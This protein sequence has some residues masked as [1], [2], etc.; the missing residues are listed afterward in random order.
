MFE[1]REPDLRAKLKAMIEW[2][3]KHH[4]EVFREGLWDAIN[5]A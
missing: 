5:E 3:E 4:P 2:L 1:E